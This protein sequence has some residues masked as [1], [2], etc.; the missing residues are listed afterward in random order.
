MLQFFVNLNRRLAGELA[1]RFPTFFGAPSPS[2]LDEIRH[3]IITTIGRDKPSVVME[4]GG[5]DRPIL[6]RSV[7]YHYIGLDIEK[8][9]ECEHLYDEFIT[10]SIEQPIPVPVDMIVSF[11]LLE[12]VP[13]NRLVMA[14][15]Y[16]ALRPGGSMHHYIPSAFHPYS[17]ML[18]LVGP[19]IQRILIPILRPGTEDVTGYPAFFNH[20]SP[21]QM[22]NIIR[23]QGFTSID[24]QAYYRANDYFAFFIP[25]YIVVT[26]FENLCRWLG[27]RRFASGFVVSATKV[28]G[29][30]GAIN[31]CQL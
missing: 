7:N 30:P 19:K 8:R 18:R 12:H 28:A 4:A 25:A 10:Q 11:T 9:P 24:I 14:A 21:D 2:Y 26:V 13:N 6:Y 20:C 3:R 16:N 1:T 27:I 15:A 31:N 29:I 5:V 23:E 17:L 22:E